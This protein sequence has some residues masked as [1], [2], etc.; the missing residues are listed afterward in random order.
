M[1]VSMDGLRKHLILNYNSLVKK[2]NNSIKYKTFDSHIII[3]HAEHSLVKSWMAE[4][5][6][7]AKE[8]YKYTEE[9][10]RKAFHIGRL[11]Q[12]REGDT[13]VEQFIQSL[14]QPKLPIAFECEMVDFEVDMGLGE[15]CIE[16]GQYPK[17]ITNSEGRTEWVGKYIFN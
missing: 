7:K 14:N 16:Y 11:Y 10:L 4:F 5:Y 6:N 12:S 13:T 9:D 1:D 2:L 3:D 17:K 15:E 8:T